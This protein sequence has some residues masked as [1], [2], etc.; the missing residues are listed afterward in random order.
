[1]I[2]LTVLMKVAAEKES[3]FL[4]AVKPLIEGSITETGCRGYYLT[5]MENDQYNY[6][7]HEQWENEAALDAHQQTEHYQMGVPQLVEITETLLLLSGT[8]KEV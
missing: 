5:Q 3:E 6:I 4:T 1:M 8:K 2:Y 7:L